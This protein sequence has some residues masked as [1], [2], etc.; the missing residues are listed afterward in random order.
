[1]FCYD[2]EEKVGG[3]NRGNTQPELPVMVLPE[4]VTT[5][6]DTTTSHDQNGLVFSVNIAALGI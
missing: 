6:N 5:S 1:V 4:T 3:A 2:S